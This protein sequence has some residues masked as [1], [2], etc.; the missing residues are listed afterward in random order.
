MTQNKRVHFI[1]DD[2]TAGDL[3]RRFSRDKDYDVSISRDPVKALENIRQHGSDLVVTDLSMPGLSG[4]DLL[5]AIRQVNI[6]L[7]V[8]MITGFSTEENAIRALRLG[9]TDFLKKP[10]DMDEL[11]RLIDKNLNTA[12]QR[13][14]EISSR[15][16]MADKRNQHGMIGNA[17]SIRKIFEI[18]DRIADIRCNVIIEGESGT[19]KELVAHAIHHHSL[20]TDKPFIVIDCGSLTDTLLETELF[21]HEKGAFTGAS[22]SKPGLL[23]V[24]SGGSVFLDE[25][26]N[27]S[28]AMQMKLMRAVQS[29]QITRVGGVQPI[30]IDV[31]FIAATNR[32]IEEM[33]AAKQFR[34]DLYHRLNV[35]SIKMP[36][37]CERKEDIEPLL[38]NFIADFSRRYNRNVKGF[39][40]ASMQWMK[41][42][43]WP[44]N[45]RELRNL[46]ERSIALAESDVLHID[47]RAIKANASNGID[48]D[49]PTLEELEKRYIQKILAQCEGNREQTAKLL[50]INKST[51]WRK[52]QVWQEKSG[53]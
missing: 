8:I 46:V 50:G 34:H 29:Q 14:I 41:S 31:R 16:R 15:P 40:E 47:Q 19:G 51:L 38:Q 9:A 3:F 52:M 2:A 42:Y 22:Q 23:E 25:I 43:S 1:D 17:A 30:N 32:N 4:L 24:A 6:E 10:F 45:I 35:V 21:G 13:E 39:D 12:Q 28:D 18:I 36:P 33:I 49:N 37:L 48:A 20:F 26:C 27:I 11:L 44:G 7:P 5:Q 53:F